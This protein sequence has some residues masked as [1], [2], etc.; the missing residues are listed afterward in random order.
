MT[1]PIVSSPGEGRGQGEPGPGLP[2]PLRR[3]GLI[4]VA[5]LGG[6]ASIGI[7]ASLAESAGP[8][9]LAA[10]F[11]LAAGTLSVALGALLR[12]HRTATSERARGRLAGSA[13]PRTIDTA[14]PAAYIAAALLA[15]TCLLTGLV[16]VVV[17]LGTTEDPAG[18]PGVDSALSD[19]RERARVRASEGAGE[20]LDASSAT[21]RRSAVVGPNGGPV[22]ADGSEP[23]SIG[24]LLSDEAMLQVLLRGDLAPST[25]DDI[26]RTV[27][28]L[29]GFVI[30]TF[31]A[32]GVWRERSQSSR[33]LA[34]GDD[35][36]RDGWLSDP[37]DESARGSEAVELELQTTSTRVELEVDFVRRSNGLV[38]APSRLL[39]VACEV[40]DDWRLAPGSTS[41][42]SEGIRGYTV[43]SELRR[44]SLAEL[45][46]LRSRGTTPPSSPCTELPP[47]RS[48]DE[49]YAL[50]SLKS[51]AQALTSGAATDI[52]RVIAVV[53]HLRNEFGYELYDVDFLNPEGCRDLIAR[54]SGSCSHFA[55]L[56]TTLL[57]SLE[58]PTRIA[59]GY[60][61]REPLADAPGWVA[62]ARDGHAWIEVHF[63]GHGWLTFDPTPG[64]ATIGGTLQDW[65]PLDDGEGA[66][67]GTRPSPTSPL[68][69]L[70]LDGARALA[71]AARQ[72]TSA[73]GA[74]WV[75]LAAL[76]GAAAAWLIAKRGRRPARAQATGP[77]PDSIARGAPH[78]AVSDFLAA[79]AERGWRQGLEPTP[80]A[81]ARRVEHQDPAGRGV[82]SAMRAILTRACTGSWP[83]RRS[84]AE[85]E[86]TTVTLREADALTPGQSAP[87]RHSR[88]YDS[89]GTATG[90]GASRPESHRGGSAGESPAGRK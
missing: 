2:G 30:D 33:P 62:R 55:S 39:A 90:A 73:L 58:V 72:A 51:Y 32:Q 25:R 36:R 76:L 42:A 53:L 48:S 14:A 78:P 21:A 16:E 18:Q 6:A 81:L 19:A 28:H 50:A 34:D 26:L 15:L 56:A 13:L 79:L 59:A 71:A 22:R 46:G 27:L 64:D 7:L 1:S 80:T 23:T 49:R 24:D 9:D 82:A 37:L 11:L 89:G 38:F 65:T 31:D 66:D 69:R 57:R 74:G 75:A 8:V 86:R 4:G 88:G 67:T 52:D 63:E 54:G 3:A 43:T 61:A 85:I 70:V 60:L 41:L 47:W 44:L 12:L 84:E 83:D 29:R 35:G 20:V 68:G 10:R 77:R 17:A 87:R 5:S 45:R 40:A